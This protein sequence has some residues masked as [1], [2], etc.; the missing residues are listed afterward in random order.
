MC[1][2][3]SPI[4][5]STQYESLFRTRPRITVIAVDNVAAVAGLAVLHHRNQAD[6]D[7]CAEHV[8][9]ETGEKQAYGDVE[10]CGNRGWANQMEMTH[11]LMQF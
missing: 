7:I 11:F 8:G 3:S 5:E 1:A 9:C 2:L 4:E 6:G 10:A